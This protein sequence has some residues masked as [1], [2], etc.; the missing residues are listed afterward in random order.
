MQS[1]LASSYQ[2]LGRNDDV[3]RMRRDV[4]FGRLKLYGKEDSHT[5]LEANNYGAGLVNSGRFGEARS[6]L[7]KTIPVARRV[8]GDNDKVTLRM[9]MNY[10]A[11]LCKDDGATVDHFREAV[12]TY[13][14]LERTA[15]RVLGGSHPL[16][17]T[18]VKYLQKAQA[19]CDAWDARAARGSA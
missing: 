11:A 7:R 13:E 1:T 17:T 19:V 9:R 6:L 10:V 15:R 8:L 18:I 16:T 5:L 14:E 2:I 4:Y 12:T 3:L